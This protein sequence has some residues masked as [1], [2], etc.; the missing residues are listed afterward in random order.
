MPGGP[1]DSAP[2]AQR[3][4]SD[5]R[6]GDGD[7]RHGRPAG[8]SVPADVRRW[9]VLTAYAAV[10]VALAVVATPHRVGD[11]PEYMGMAQ[12]L[13]RL[14]AP[15]VTDPAAVEARFNV[16]PGWE[17]ARLTNLLATPAG[18]SVYSHLWSYPL[19]VAGPMAAIEALGLH[20]NHAFTLTNIILLLVAAALVLPRLGIAWTALLFVGPIIWWVDKAHNEIFTFALLAIAMALYRDRPGLALVAVGA[21]ASNYVPLAALIPVLAA[22]A[23]WQDRATIRRASFWAGAA[24]GLA[25]AALYPV[26]YIATLGRP[27]PLLGPYGQ[28]HLPTLAEVG[29]LFWDLNM[30]LATNYPGLILAVGVALVLIARSRRL[31]QF[32]PD[33]ALLVVLAMPMIVGAT[34]PW[35]LHTG[36]TFGLNRYAIWFMPLAI[37]LLRAVG[38]ADCRPLLVATIAASVVFSLWLAAPS[39]KHSPLQPNFA[40]RFAWRYLPALEN[41]LPE[42]FFE[43]VAGPSCAKVLV[44]NGGWPVECPRPPELPAAGLWYANLKSDGYVLIPAPLP[45]WP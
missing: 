23:I 30:G 34:Q 40:A 11:G 44:V 35:N 28:L 7:G 2:G 17:T 4:E 27:I 21:A 41:P 33:L 1:L 31:P 26:F 37:P 6:G 8:A 9:A 12:S 22:F 19:L 14:E 29:T 24:A 3:G 42:V 20:I 10:L 5:G 13:A 25:L 36:G 32:A 45:G 16:W 43:T 38:P 39:T 15:I 18:S